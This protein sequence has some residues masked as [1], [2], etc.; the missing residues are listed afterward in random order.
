MLRTVRGVWRARSLAL[1]TK[2]AQNWLDLRQAVLDRLKSENTALLQCLSALENP[3]T[4]PDP[5]TN[6]EGQLVP[7]PRAGWTAVCEE[8]AQLEAELKQRDKRMLRL[9]QVFAGKTAEFREAL[10]VIF[11]IKLA[12][13]DNGQDEGGGEARLQLAVQGEG[14][15]L[16]LLQLM[17]NW[18]EIKQGI[19]CFL[20]SFT[21]EYY[22]KWKRKQ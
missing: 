3:P 18:V 11:G 4:S 7:V 19:S 8:R 14:G 15:P 6:G 10:S 5:D 13:Y 21:L 2:P 17:R 16:E 1:C 22:D 20:A 12:F 9:R